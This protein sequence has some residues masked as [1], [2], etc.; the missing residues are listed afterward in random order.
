[1]QV[2]TV[3]G[4]IVYVVRGDA[5]GNYLRN[6]YGRNVVLPAVNGDVLFNRIDIFDSAWTG[7]FGYPFG[8]ASL[9]GNDLA[10]GGSFGC[11]NPGS[12]SSGY[13]TITAIGADFI[14]CANGSS[15][16]RFNL[17]SCSRL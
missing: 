6:L 5:F 12:I 13:G 17:G 4:I 7:A 15:K 3:G 16:T 9:G 2:Q 10:F 14:E 8:S 11:T 1:M